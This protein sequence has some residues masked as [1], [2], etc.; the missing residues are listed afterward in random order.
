MPAG[1]GGVDYS[2]PGDVLWEHTF[3]KFN[4]TP[5]LHESFE[6]YYDPSAVPPIVLDDNHHEY[7]QYDIFLDSA[8]WFWQDSGT[9]YWLNIEAQVENPTSP[10]QWG[11]KSSIEHF[12]DDAVWGYDPG[13]GPC[14]QPDP[15]FPSPCPYDFPNGPLVATEGLPA[16]SSLEFDVSYDSFFDIVV[17]NGGNLGGQIITF[18][19]NSTIDVTGTGALATFGRMLSAQ[20]DFEVHTAPH[21]GE[22]TIDIELVSMS[23]SLPPG[24]PDFNMLEIRGG[25][26]FGLPGT[27]KA[28]FSQLSNGDWTV[29]SFFDIVYRIDFQGSPGSIL[30]DM[31][32][33]TTDGPV[34]LQQ[35]GAK[36]DGWTDLYEPPN[37]DISLDLAF[38]ITGEP[39]QI[40][41]CEPGNANGDATI[42]IFDITYIIT[43][44]Y[45]AGPAPIPYRICSADP[46]C[47]CTV[48]IFDV[49]YLISYLYI[50]GPAPC[51]CQDWLTACGPPLRK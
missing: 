23:L 48:N 46:N 28:K 26:S 43:Y 11:W 20:A 10:G 32:G 44:L 38:V 51:T 49:T 17:A 37:F 6:G 24:D 35:G 36:V 25:T 4:A 31:G 40:C 7:F 14:P 33:S 27:G 9:I 29:D 5:K 16:G 42:N 2:R 34:R 50:Q 8:T 3:T 22:Q 21:S 30:Q 18:S 13:P 41:D 39:G 47:D 1:T 19:A 12:N 15:S 45:L